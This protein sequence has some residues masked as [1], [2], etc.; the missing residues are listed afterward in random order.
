MEINGKKA[1]KTRVELLVQKTQEEIVMPSIKQ[2]KNSFP[3]IKKAFD[4]STLVAIMRAKYDHP[5]T[6]LKMALENLE[7]RKLIEVENGF[8]ILNGKYNG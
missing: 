2:G 3:E 1:D 6:Y 7:G 5:P 4:D 8:Y